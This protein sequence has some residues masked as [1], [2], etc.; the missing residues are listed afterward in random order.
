[1]QTISLCM[2]VKNEET[3]I[4]NC[5]NSVY[6]LI[7]EIVIVDTGSTDNTKNIC[8]KYTNK[9][10]DYIWDYDFGKARTYSFSLATSDYILWLDADDII[11]SDNYI[12]LQEL[13]NNMDG[14][15][16]VYNLWYD[17]RH[18]NL[19]KC[20]YT[21]YRERIIKNT[22]DVYWDCIVHELLHFNKNNIITNT[23]IRITHTSNHD[24]SKKYI[25]YFEKKIDDGYKLNAREKYFY[26]TELIK[27]NNLEKAFPYIKSFINDKKYNFGYDNSYEIS[28]GYNWLGDYYKH[29]HKYKLA[30]KSYYMGI[31]YHQPLIDTYYNIAECYSNLGNY[32]S[33]IF[34][35][36]III[37]TDFPIEIFLNGS[38]FNNLNTLYKT[39]DFRIKSLL[40]L[41]TIHYYHLNNLQLSKAYNEKILILDPHNESALYNK[42][43][44]DTLE[45]LKE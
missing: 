13:K 3:F 20:I 42:N 2:I 11:T 37:E 7:D 9:I 21:F 18:D 27:N 22:P 45:I 14:S 31:A 16:G 8:K 4:N 29:I 44:F 24:N 19:G 38:N 43:F 39:R 36:N 34:Y 32:N 41:V 28:R 6:K 15:V 23:D 33:A 35:Y 25:E 1:M 5:L 26:S 30:L 10:Y 17:Y 40:N 12:K